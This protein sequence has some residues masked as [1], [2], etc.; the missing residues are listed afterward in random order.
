ML[1]ISLGP[2]AL[3]VSPLILML[4]V[5]LAASL[6]RRLAPADLRQR[7]ENTVWLASAVGLLSARVGYVLLHA[8]A[9]FATPIDMLDLRDGGWL[10]VAGLLVGCLW[11][12]WRGWQRPTMRRAL[13]WAAL[14]GVALWLTGNWLVSMAGGGAA[15]PSVPEVM[16]TD[17][18]TGQ[19]RSLAQVIA[20]RPAVVNLWASW[21]GPCRAEM[22]VLAAAQQR[23]PK[24]QFVFVNQGESSQTVLAFLQRSTADLQNV[25]MD[26]GSALGPASGSKGLPTTLFFDAH[27]R[28]VD[29]HFGLINAAAL[30]ARL[31]PLRSPD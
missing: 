30:Q 11:L 20:G 19:V 17:I 5:W 25:W 10:A 13:V 21:C 1:S 29:A 18:R 22:P 26:A 7:G 28:R 3:P 12:L 8:D 9:Y 16:L 24:I 4:A 2:L 6:A 23:E 31:Q 14:A 27:G 15:R